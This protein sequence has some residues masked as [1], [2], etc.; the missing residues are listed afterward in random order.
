MTVVDSPTRHHGG[1]AA[2][3]ES[4]GDSTLLLVLVAR[5]G[6]DAD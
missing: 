5:L 4:H 6:L 2:V 3:A 1:F